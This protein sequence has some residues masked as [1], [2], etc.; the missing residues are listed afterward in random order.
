MQNLLEKTS[1]LHPAGSSWVNTNSAQTVPARTARSVNET[2]YSGVLTTSVYTTHDTSMTA[3]PIRCVTLTNYKKEKIQIEQSSQSDKSTQ[4]TSTIKIRKGS[5]AAASRRALKALRA[6][7]KKTL[8]AQPLSAL[9]RRVWCLSLPASLYRDPWFCRCRMSCLS[10]PLAVEG[11]H[12]NH[13]AFN[14][15]KGQVE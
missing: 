8:F 14:S 10:L 5:A 11:K 6:L 7:K 1:Q 3:W 4:H 9:P 15:K 13:R 2:I 12:S